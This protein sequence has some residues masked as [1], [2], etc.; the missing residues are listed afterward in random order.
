VRMGRRNLGQVEENFMK[1][2]RPGDVFVL[3]G[4]CVRLVKSYLLTAHVVAADKSL[5]TIPRWYANKMPLASG[6]AR[7]VVRLRTELAKRLR[8]AESPEVGTDLRAVRDQLGSGD[9]PDRH[10]AGM[11]GG[12]AAATFEAIEYLISEYKFSSA[13]ARALVEHF[14]LQAR[15]STIP[16]AEIFLVEV[17]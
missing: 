17:F 15:F 6:L 14:A 5:P 3:N 7:E 8:G 4:R 9:R 1:S 13:N 10:H 16:T 12:T 11:A 2:V